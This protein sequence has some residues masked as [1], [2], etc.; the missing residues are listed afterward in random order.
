MQLPVPRGADLPC[1]GAAGNRPRC[2]WAC[3]WPQVLGECQ[4]A[5]EGAVG[6]A[7]PASPTY[8]LLLGAPVEGGSAARSLAPSLQLP[9]SWAP[10]SRPGW[11][12]AFQGGVQLPGIRGMGLG[13]LEG[14]ASWRCF[15]FDSGLDCSWRL[16]CLDL[17]GS[18]PW[19]LPRW[20]HCFHRPRVSLR[21]DRAALGRLN[22][23][24]QH[25]RPGASTASTR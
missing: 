5:W 21:W 12:A 19:L 18:L 20:T 16:D 14:Q 15:G 11:L 22:A 13:R 3:M 25:P 4:P 10:H 17:T 2:A 24:L 6:S 23:S 7:S 1:P 9:V 8:N